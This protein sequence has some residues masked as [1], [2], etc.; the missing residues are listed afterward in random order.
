MVEDLKLSQWFCTFGRKQNWNSSLP[1]HIPWFLYSTHSSALASMLCMALAI[2]LRN[3][4]VVETPRSEG[5]SRAHL[6]HPPAPG[7]VNAELRQG[8]SGP[9]PVRSQKPPKSK[10]Q[11]LPKGWQ[12]PTVVQE[13]RSVVRLREVSW[14]PPPAEG[15]CHC[16]GNDVERRS[17][18]GAQT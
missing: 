10:P 7:K 13:Y 5:T 3:R 11:R 15:R 8:C 1:W 18:L 17:S 12:S 4:R 2:T 6:I 14:F 16:L 9:Y